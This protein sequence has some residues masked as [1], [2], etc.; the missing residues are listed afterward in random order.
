MKQV[1]TTK[2]LF[3]P[4]SP[5]HPSINQKR[6]FSKYL[7]ILIAGVVMLIT[8]CQKEN[9]DS[10]SQKQNSLN[11]FQKQN[12]LSSSQKQQAVPFNAKFVTIDEGSINDSTE[13]ITGTGEGTHIGKSTFVA[14]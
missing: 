9:M 14:F 6:V 11:S 5:L 10:S 13:R 2:N 8:S 1:L 7:F 3:V 12:L 4:H